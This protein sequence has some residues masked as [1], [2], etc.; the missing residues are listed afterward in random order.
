MTI[1]SQAPNGEGS[2]TI[3]SA[4]SAVSRVRPKQDGS[5]QPQYDKLGEDI[6][7]SSWKREA[8]LKLLF[9]KVKISKTGCWE[10]QG[11]KTLGYGSFRIPGIYD[12]KK[13]LAHRAAYTAFKGELIPKD[14][15]VCHHCDN[16]KCFN[17]DHLFLGSQSDNIQDCADKN[18]IKSGFKSNLGKYSDQQIEEVKRLLEQGKN[19]RE[20]NEI[21]GIS[22]T[23]I[24]RIK[25]GYSRKAQPNPKRTLKHEEAYRVAR[26]L[27]EDKLLSTQ[28]ADMVGVPLHIVKD[29]KRGKGYQEFMERVSE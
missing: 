6:V 4:Q 28:I 21:T 19:G 3:E 11:S 8:V 29:M 26:L 18:R 1:S 24:S 9:T 7:R 20:I 12:D 23:H 5:A 14:I 16:P 22:P 10:W 17:P 15:F 13:I 27:K 2:E 25:R